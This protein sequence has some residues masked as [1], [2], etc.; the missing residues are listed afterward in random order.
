MTVST[1]ST[2]TQMILAWSLLGALLVWLVIFAVLA[3]HARQVEQKDADELPTPAHSF[4]AI[5][6]QMT[7]QQNTLAQVGAPLSNTH[8]HMAPVSSHSGRALQQTDHSD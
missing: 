8:P 1:L 3:L 6:V 5:T 4:P 2:P 7:Q